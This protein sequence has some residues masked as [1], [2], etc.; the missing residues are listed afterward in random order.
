M[1]VPGLKDRVRAHL[2]DNGCAVS[3]WMSSQ[4]IAL[5]DGPGSQ[6]PRHYTARFTRRGAVIVAAMPDCARKRELALPP[7]V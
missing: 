6:N 7:E 4:R 3:Y 5:V 1:S 2:E